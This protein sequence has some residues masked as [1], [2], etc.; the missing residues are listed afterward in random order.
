MASAVNST[1]R[2]LAAVALLGPLVLAATAVAASGGHARP[3][4]PLRIFAASSL[5]EAFRAVDARSAYSFAGSDQ[6]TV[7][8][9]NGAPADLFASA[10]PS[11][12]QDLFR[13]GLV[14]RPVTFT[15][16]RIVIVV[17]KGNPAGISSIF[18][19]AASDVRIVLAAPT[20]PAGEYARA[21]I[22]KLGLG[23]RI[24]PKVVS[25]EPDVK[26]VLAKVAL[27]EADAGFVYATDAR[28]VANDVIV[29]AIPA[30]AQPRIRYEIAVVRSS[31]NR[32][33]ARRW[34]RSL[35]S[36]RGQT[37]LRHAGFAPIPGR[38]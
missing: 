32:A 3:L 25:N 1:R 8:I 34:I 10:S 26:S 4:A 5:T 9:E 24:L 23:P 20:V 35:L 7:Q 12:T 11:F 30:R 15:A 18:D 37:A 31:A 36:G 29:V 19:L 16:N 22:R 33:A 38:G 28:S 13:K 21:A 6:L 17:P 27:G 14:E 2:R